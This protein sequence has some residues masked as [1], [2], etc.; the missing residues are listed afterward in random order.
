MEHGVPQAAQ[1]LTDCWHAWQRRAG[2]A[3]IHDI[4][5]G[6]TRA[7]P[8]QKP[9]ALQSRVGG[10]RVVQSR[11][12]GH[13]VVQGRAGVLAELG[14]VSVHRHCL[15]VQALVGVQ[16]HHVQNHKDRLRPGASFCREKPR[17]RER[18]KRG[19][20]RERER[21]GRVSVCCL[22]LIMVPLRRGG[23]MRNKRADNPLRET[24]VRHNNPLNPLR[25]TPVRHN[26]SL[27]ETRARH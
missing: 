15:A 8:G 5:V 3:G 20:K 10:R 26:N 23:T 27:S 14:G 7:G 12:R 19:K 6:R 25:E 17:E 1:L 18:G 22:C 4:S 13:R 9:W 16:C 2:A 24:P 21:R 11:A